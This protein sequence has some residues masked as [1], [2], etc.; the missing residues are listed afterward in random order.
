[1]PC[2]EVEDSVVVIP[3]L[4]VEVHGRMPYGEDTKQ[5]RVV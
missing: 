2:G 1:M 5:C 3:R 4:V